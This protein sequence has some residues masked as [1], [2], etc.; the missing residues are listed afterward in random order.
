MG[1][2]DIE[3]LADAL[4]QR[5]KVIDTL[6]VGI[7]ALELFRHDEVELYGARLCALLIG[8]F[9][10][11]IVRD[12]SEAYIHLLQK[13]FELALLADQACN[14]LEAFSKLVRRQRTLGALTQV[15]E[16]GTKLR[17]SRQ[18]LEHRDDHCLNLSVALDRIHQTGRSRLGQF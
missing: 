18:A 3:A 14:T 16:H 17:Q 1:C 9:S 4:P 11:K 15:G 12:L 2:D 8:D 6:D 13:L 5:S 7:Q 10:C